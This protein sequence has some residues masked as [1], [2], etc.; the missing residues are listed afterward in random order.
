[1]NKLSIASWLTIGFYWLL[2]LLLTCS[3]LIQIVRG[4]QIYGFEVWQIPMA[5]LPIIGV[6]LAVTATKDA[7]KEDNPKGV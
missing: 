3:S 5:I 2:A 4:Y 6:L 1:M 7:I